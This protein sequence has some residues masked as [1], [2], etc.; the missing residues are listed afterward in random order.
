MRFSRYGQI[1]SGYD[2]HPLLDML[3]KTTPKPRNSFVYVASDPGLEG[4]PV[5]AQLQNRKY[6]GM[7]IQIGYCNG[8]NSRLNCLEYHRGSELIIPTDDIIL[9]LGCQSDLNDFRLD[10]GLIEAFLL[11]AGTGI[12]LY[13]TTLH[14][15]PC[16]SKGSGGYRAINVLPKGTNEAAPQGLSAEGEDRLCMGRNKWLIAHHEAPEA[17][18]GAF[19]GL[20]GENL[21]INF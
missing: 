14:Y 16:C 19:V 12:E 20:T 6:G 18:Q 3:T 1:L 8:A 13:A 11:P 7:P 17:K 5:A 9:L 2:F 15:A 10:T 4:L 21:V